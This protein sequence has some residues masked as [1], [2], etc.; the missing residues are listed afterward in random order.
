MGKSMAS[1]T[2]AGRSGTTERA[3]RFTIEAWDV[4]CPQHIPR[5]IDAERAEARIEA[6]RARV[7]E[8]EAALEAE[9]DR[10]RS[11]ESDE[12]HPDANV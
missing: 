11:A 7:A 6:L 1:V 8:L 10:A 5:K 2:P 3:F 12:S 4:N 9:R